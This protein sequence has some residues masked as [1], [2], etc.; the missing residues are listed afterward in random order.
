VQD[1]AK[2][3]WINLCV[4]ASIEQDPD[5]LIRLIREINNFLEEKQLRLSKLRAAK[6]GQERASD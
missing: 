2:E 1:E 5:E 3:H 4:Q 6:G